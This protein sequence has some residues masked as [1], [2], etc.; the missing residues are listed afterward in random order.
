ME[1]L[2]AGSLERQQGQGDA[3]V[4]GQVMENGAEEGAAKGSPS[5]NKKREGPS[6]ICFGLSR[7][8]CRGSPSL[9][10]GIEACHPCV[11]V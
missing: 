7:Q 11:P 8:P 5:H 3:V 1:P 4:E 2:K 6:M 9:L 10:L